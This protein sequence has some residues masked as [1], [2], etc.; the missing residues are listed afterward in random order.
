VAAPDFL[1]AAA[2]DSVDIGY[3]WLRREGRNVGGDYV[4]AAGTNSRHRTGR[5][6]VSD[7]GARLQGGGLEAKVD[8]ENYRRAAASDDIKDR[9]LE[10]SPALNLYQL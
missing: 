2:L 3:R 1:E 7:V 5:G 8:E 4:E 9:M 10:Q 6:A